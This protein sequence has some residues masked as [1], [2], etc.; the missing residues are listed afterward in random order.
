[1]AHLI[2][3]NMLTFDCTLD[4]VVLIGLPVWTHLRLQLKLVRQVRAWQP[5]MFEDRT[6]HQ[7]SCTIVK[8][9]VGSGELE[10]AMRSR[11]CH[12][13]PGSRCLG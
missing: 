10:A 6:A 9:K 11:N 1:M 2:V 12:F 13:E 5:A 8:C 3:V 7:A 4:A